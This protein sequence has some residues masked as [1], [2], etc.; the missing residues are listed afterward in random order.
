[1]IYNAILPFKILK[2]FLQSENSEAL[3]SY[4]NSNV[5]VQ[6]IEI[7]PTFSFNSRENPSYGELGLND[8]IVKAVGVH[9]IYVLCESTRPINR[10]KKEKNIRF[11]NNLFLINE[12]IC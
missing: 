3:P 10:K 12:K 8:K 11:S 1:L 6:H 5:I 9:Q 4:I 2:H 7:S